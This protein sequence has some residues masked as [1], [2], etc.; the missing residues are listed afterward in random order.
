MIVG[1]VLVHD[2]SVRSGLRRHAIQMGERF[3]ALLLVPAQP[4]QQRR[5]SRVGVAWRAITTPA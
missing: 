2:W 1:V 5:P 3:V 4:P